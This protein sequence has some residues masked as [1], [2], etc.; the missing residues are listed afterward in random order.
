MELL[1]CID[2]LSKSCLQSHYRIKFKLFSQAVPTC[3]CIQYKTYCIIL[4]VELG[5]ANGESSIKLTY[6]IQHNL[7]TS[8]RHSTDVLVPTYINIS[9]SRALPR[10]I[11]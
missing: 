10:Y 5:S 4:L 8:T 9:S 7:S 2:L 3:T 6:L 11:R 1:A